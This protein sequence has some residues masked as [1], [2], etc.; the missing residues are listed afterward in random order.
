MHLEIVTERLEREVVTFATGINAGAVLRP[1][2]VI[3]IQDADDSG[4]QLSGRVTTS[5][6]S[7]TT[8]IKTDR[9]LS[10][11]LDSNNNY[12]LF[13]PVVLSEDETF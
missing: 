3:N 11:T 1:G 10:S 5:S 9:D 2:D 4:T 6:S 8:V 13:L 12:E 7:T